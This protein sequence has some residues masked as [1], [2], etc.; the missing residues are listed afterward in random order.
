MCVKLYPIPVREALDTVGKPLFKGG[1]G[2][3]AVLTGTRV[4]RSRP[5]LVCALSIS[6]NPSCADT[7]STSAPYTTCARTNHIE[8]RPPI[9]MKIMSYGHVDCALLVHLSHQLSTPSWQRIQVDVTSSHTSH[10]QPIKYG[11]PRL[12]LS[13]KRVPVRQYQGATCNH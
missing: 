9:F 7:T 13:T 8:H 3:S 5:C 6:T 12:V 2:T 10:S 1:P 11:A 4:S